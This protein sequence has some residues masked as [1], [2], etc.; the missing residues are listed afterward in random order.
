[1]DTSSFSAVFGVLR[2]SGV[3][4]TAALVWGCPQ[5]LTDDFTTVRVDASTPGD[6]D[7][8]PP[9]DAEACAPFAACGGTCVDLQSNALH[10]GGCDESVAA[11]QICL[12]GSAV[13]ESVG[14]GRRRLCG[15]SCVDSQ[16]NPFHCGSCDLACERGARCMMGRCECAPGTRDCGIECRQCC[17]DR[18]CPMDRTCVDGSCLLLC[19]PTLVGCM[20]RCVNLQTEPHHCGRC[21]NDC[22]PMGSCVGGTCAEP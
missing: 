19:D 12:Q 6:V 21:G 5:A 4:G 22:G 7:A 1:L 13:A 15:R 16:S 3:I 8:S 14:C 17:S 11:E 18:D 2:V 9:P 20:D 10:C